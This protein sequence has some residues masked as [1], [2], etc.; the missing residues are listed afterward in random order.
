MTQTRS[1][2]TVERREYQKIRARG[3]RIARHRQKARELRRHE[4]GRIPRPCYTKSERIA[5]RVK[6]SRWIQP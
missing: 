4:E 5:T 6:L 1:V 3:S 2:S